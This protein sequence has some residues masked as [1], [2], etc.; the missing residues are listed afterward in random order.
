[1]TCEGDLRS[2]VMFGPQDCPA[3]LCEI[4]PLTWHTVLS[5]EPGGILF[6]TKAG[7]FDAS[8]AKTFAPFAPAEDSPKASHY[9]EQLRS[10]GLRMVSSFQAHPK[11][12]ITASQT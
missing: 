3:V 11:A 8:R 12:A 6:E 9:L 7:P 4:A 2:A 5:L 10:A 1:M